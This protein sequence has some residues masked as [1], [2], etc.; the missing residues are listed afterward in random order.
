M[1]DFKFL[2]YFMNLYIHVVLQS[3]YTL[4][5][6]CQ[7]IFNV[8]CHYTFSCGTSSYSSQQTKR[9]G[10]YRSHVQITDGL[11]GHEFYKVNIGTNKQLLYI[12][13]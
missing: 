7:V 10:L 1:A 12:I 6:N 3:I 13:R 9:I 4:S 8:S 5:R 11:D 2:R